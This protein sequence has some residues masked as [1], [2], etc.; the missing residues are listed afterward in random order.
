MQAYPKL[1]GLCTCLNAAT[2]LLCRSFH[3]SAA[4]STTEESQFASEIPVGHADSSPT[5]TLQIT[6]PGGRA[7][8]TCAHP[9]K[10]L[11]LRPRSYPH[12]KTQT[13]AHTARNNDAP[14]LAR[15]LLDARHLTSRISA[16]P[17]TWQST[18]GPL[19]CWPWLL[20]HRCLMSCWRPAH[21][22]TESSVKEGTTHHAF[23]REQC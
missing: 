18:L 20:Q 11:H 6:S 19:S 16:W 23:N 2:T 15:C 9:L 21:I 8:S 10:P 4:Q 17:A 1:R 12:T 14:H 13:N 5:H 7:H 3:L 22:Q